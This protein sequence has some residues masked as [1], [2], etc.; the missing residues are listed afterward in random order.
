MTADDPEDVA[1]AA[2]TFADLMDLTGSKTFGEFVERFAGWTFEEIHEFVE[3]R[4]D[5]ST[6]EP[7]RRPDCDYADDTGLADPGGTHG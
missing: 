5:P 4:A 2:E 6:P 3:R 1:R 7:E